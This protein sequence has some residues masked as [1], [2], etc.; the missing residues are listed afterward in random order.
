MQ[1]GMARRTR[2]PG[3]DAREIMGETIGDQEVLG[4]WQG[5]QEDA[6]EH[7]RRERTTGGPGIEGGWGRT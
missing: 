2:A 3:M 6:K 4:K 1:T 7:E 5:A